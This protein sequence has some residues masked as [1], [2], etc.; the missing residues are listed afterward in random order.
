[1][2]ILMLNHEFPPVGGGAGNACAC[3]AHELARMGVE[4]TVVTSAF[5]DLPRREE[6]SCLRLIRV[7]VPRRVA[8]EASSFEV[9]CFAPSGLLAAVRSAY[10]H[11][12]DVVHAFFGVPSG[13]MAWAMNGATG[14]PYLIS[15]RGRDVHG[16]KDPAA[17]G[18]AGPLKVVSRIAWRRA[19]ALVANSKGLRDL[20]QTVDP[21][22]SVRV[23]P[24]GVDVV[25]FSPGAPDSSAGGPLRLLFVGRLEPY[26]GIETLLEAA[27]Q[28]RGRTSRNLALD[29]VGDGSLRDH[30]PEVARRLGLQ[31]MVRFCGLAPPDRMPDVYRQADV[32]VLPSIVEG[33]PNVILEAMASGLPVVATRIPGS[34]ELV[35]PGRTGFLVPPGDAQALAEAVS[36]LAEQ[37][38]LRRVM[39][40]D[41]RLEAQRRSWNRVTEAYLSIYRETIGETAPCVAS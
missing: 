28:L 41:A 23:I 14:L 34:D 5:R 39:S 29:L 16:G 27:G 35:E 11:R 9:S 19:S 1:M 30:L 12:P 32:F 17:G 13:A 6:S 10:R 21:R 22:V 20:A 40:T 26:K 7:P 36:R 31:D 37:P 25:R 38:D 15:F 3:I 24:N 33:M 2:R 8:L 4:V 18:I